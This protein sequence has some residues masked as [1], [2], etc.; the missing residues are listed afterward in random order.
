MCVRGIKCDS[1]ST[2]VRLDF[3][4]VST[5]LYFLYFFI[6]FNLLAYTDYII[7]DISHSIDGIHYHE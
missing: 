7:D 3:G 1:V 6:L 2:F 5:V 4:T